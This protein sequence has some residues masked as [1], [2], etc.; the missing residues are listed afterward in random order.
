MTVGSVGANRATQVLCLKY[1]ALSSRQ[2]QALPGPR[3]VLRANSGSTGHLEDSRAGGGCEPSGEEE[4]TGVCPDAEA[5]CA[6][7][8]VCDTGESGFLWL[9][10]CW[11][12]LER[13]RRALICFMG[14]AWLCQLEAAAC[15]LSGSPGLGQGHQRTV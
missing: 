15:I 13:C 11:S 3:R 12:E 4:G 9:A 2:L 1:C 14:P 8:D 10:P 7:T 6:G 5:C